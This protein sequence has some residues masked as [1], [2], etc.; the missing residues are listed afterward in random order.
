[1]KGPDD[2]SV[3][4][5][6]SAATGSASLCQLLHPNGVSVVGIQITTGLTGTVVFETTQD[7]GLTWMSANVIKA[8][9]FTTVAT[10]VNPGTTNYFFLSGAFDGFRVRCSAFTSGSALVQVNASTA[11]ANLSGVFA[12]TSAVSFSGTSPSSATTTVS[13]SLT[14]IDAFTKCIIY[15]V[16]TGATGGTL[17]VVLQSTPDGGTTWYDVCHYTQIVAAAAAV[18]NFVSLTRGE[19]YSTTTPVVVNS[20]STT[21]V[22]A[23]GQVIPHGLGNGLRVLYV[24][25]VGTTLGAAQVIKALFSTQ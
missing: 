14:G 22:L 13:T 19:T 10:V 21:P 8:S 18:G 12:N 24:A 15:A 5:T 1:M 11:N 25:G 2:F 4:T 20:V 3:S 23:A 17:D 7:N 6:L 9:D 16:L